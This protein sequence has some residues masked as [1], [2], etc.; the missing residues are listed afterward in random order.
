M[1]RKETLNRLACWV[2]STDE[3]LAPRGTGEP[4]EQL[5]Y[6][7]VIMVLALL[8]HSKLPLGRLG[9]MPLCFRSFLSPRT[10]SPTPR[11]TGVFPLQHVVGTKKLCQVLLLVVSIPVL[12]HV[13]KFFHQHVAL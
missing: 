1:R 10:P 9:A 13:L 12:N 11:L 7:L 4:W 8:S 2:R 5:S 3:G 6:L